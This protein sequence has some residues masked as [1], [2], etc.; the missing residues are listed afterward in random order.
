[1]EKREEGRRQGGNTNPLR[2]LGEK[3]EGDELIY[4]E[5]SESITN[6]YSDLGGKLLLISLNVVMK[7]DRDKRRGGRI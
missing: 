3:G 4:A 7:R 6:S 5:L 2:A 1:M